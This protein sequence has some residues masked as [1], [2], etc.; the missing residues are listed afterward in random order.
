MQ[1]RLLLVPAAATARWR[2]VA[3]VTAGATLRNTS[4][5]SY[6]VSAVLTWLEGSPASVYGAIHQCAA[7]GARAWAAL[8]VAPKMGAIYGA[9]DQHRFMTPKHVNRGQ[10][11]LTARAYGGWVSHT[12]S[13]LPGAAFALGAVSTLL[14]RVPPGTLHAAHWIWSE[15]PSECSSRTTGPRIGLALVECLWRAAMSKAL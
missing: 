12:W 3:A 8:P 13:V 11:A 14:S 7:C 6:S 2:A 10:K 9:N 15:L 5:T 4:C 1:C